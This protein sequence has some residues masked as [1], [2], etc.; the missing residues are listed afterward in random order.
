MVNAPSDESERLR[1]FLKSPCLRHPPLLKGVFRRDIFHALSLLFA[2]IGV[3]SRFI[4]M[5]FGIPLKQRGIEGD[6][7]FPCAS[8]VNAPSDESD[9]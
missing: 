1:G 5:V 3:N 8:V 6:F 4:M 2:S 7:L 9:G